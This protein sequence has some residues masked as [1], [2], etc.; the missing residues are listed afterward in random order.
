MNQR[1]GMRAVEG[2]ASAWRE[3]VRVFRNGAWLGRR[4]KLVVAW[5]E[6]GRGVGEWNGHGWPGGDDVSKARGCSRLAT[7]GGGLH[8]RHACRTLFA[9]LACIASR[10]RPRRS[11]Q[12]WPGLAGQMCCIGCHL[13][14]VPTLRRP[15]AALELHVEIRLGLSA[16]RSTRGEMY[17]GSDRPS[18]PHRFDPS[19][20]HSRFLGHTSEIGSAHS[21]HHSTCTVARPTALVAVAFCSA[22]PQ[23]PH[24]TPPFVG[25]KGWLMYFVLAMQDICG[26]RTLKA[27]HPV[28]S[29]K[30]SKVSPSQYCG[31]GPRGNPRCCSS[32]F[33]FCCRCATSCS[34]FNQTKCHPQTMEQSCREA[35]Y[36]CIA[37]N[38]RRLC[39]F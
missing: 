38:S 34:S 15:T 26:H 21:S 5:I 11:R 9:G 25:S 6:G 3:G 8:F 31:G 12:F 1:S 35:M 13:G 28:R 29:A 23:A 10:T 30:L 32:F 14:C 2:G 18:P 24:T 39:C 17:N 36:Y 22:S 27:P 7:A 4:G 20:I 37:Q 16:M 33:A 19:E